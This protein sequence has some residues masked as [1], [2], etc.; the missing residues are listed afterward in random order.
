MRNLVLAALAATLCVVP[1]AQAAPPPHLLFDF[2]GTGS[3]G[4]AIDGGPAS[5]AQFS[6]PSDVAI[7]PDGRVAVADTRNHR[8]RVVGRDGFIFT[9]AG[10]GTARFSGEDGAATAAELN[11]PYGVAATPDG[12][13]LIADSGNNRVRKVSPVFPFSIDTVAGDGTPGF[14]GD[15]GDATAAQLDFPTAVAPTPDGGFLVADSGNWRVRKVSRDGT[16]TT[17]AGNGQ[18]DHSGDGIP[19]IAAGLDPAGVAAQPDGGFLIA[20]DFNSRIRRVG[21]NGMISTIAG[22]GTPGLGGDGGPANGAQLNSPSGVSLAPDGSVL[23]AD[24]RAHLVRWIDPAGIIH[25]LAGTGTAG[26]NGHARDATTTELNQ[27]FGVAVSP[28]GDVVVAER[29]GQR[30]RL[31]LAGLVPAQSAPQPPQPPTPPGTGTP[32]PQR[33]VAALGQRSLRVGRRA[34]ARLVYVLT[35]DARVTV[36][37]RRRGRRVAGTSHNGR[38]GRNQITLRRLRRPGR[39]QLRL[40]ATTGD[41]RVSVDRGRLIV[42]R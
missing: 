34:R 17:V 14:G 32:G 9:A 31:I 12:G 29:N 24:W 37:L 26:Y 11:F 3:A 15:G 1:A 25:T 38:P 30:L 16:I 5:L 18:R 20:D 33:L 40:T 28:S 27:P 8:I 22:T 35:D 7:A 2:A 6:S 41:G 42:V 4:F 23:V 13:W 19:A 10:T 36:E 21:P 39:Y